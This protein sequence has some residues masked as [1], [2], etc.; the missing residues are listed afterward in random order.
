[1]QNKEKKWIEIE[2][3]M[4]EYA[5]DDEELR[6]KFKE[7]KVNI[8]PGQKISNIVHENEKLKYECK[9]LHNEIKR[10]RKILLSP[11]KKFDKFDDRLLKHKIK[12]KFEDNQAA[13]QKV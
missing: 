1:M 2:Q 9:N 3:I 5:E 6:D 13:E 12:T 10:M 7:L 8:R 4:E 11:D